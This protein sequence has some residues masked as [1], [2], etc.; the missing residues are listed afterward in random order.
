MSISIAVLGTGIM[1][2]A[3]ARNL[4]RAGL[5]VTV[6][7]RTVERAR[8]LEADGAIVVEMAADAVARADVVLTML[9]DGPAVREVME[10]AAPA[11]RQGAVWLQCT[12]VGVD[13]VPDFAALAQRHGVTFVDAPVLGTRAPAEAGQLTV[14]SA[15]PENV[16]ATLAP[17]LEA[18]G[19]RTVWTGLDGASAASTR[20]KLVA[21]SWVIAV[22]NAAGEMVALAQALGVD[23]RQFLD[24]IEGGP[25]DSGYLRAKAGLI[26][27]DAL[28][29]PSFSVAAAGKDA[30]LI[31][32]AATA[33]GVRLDGAEAAAERFARAVAAGY[34]NEDMAAAYRASAE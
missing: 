12:T 23:P 34:G 13:E 4:A 14:L 16:R 29:P 30:E 11:M 26:L 20:L 33:H 10:E 7:N 15:G 25:L 18:V 5:D 19:S 9:F 2:A 8:P 31:V 28:T 6:W 21:N 22:S 1:G 27:D 24:L 3:M 17:V 32:A